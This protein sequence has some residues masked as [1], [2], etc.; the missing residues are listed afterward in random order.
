MK[1]V[2]MFVAFAIVAGA[3]PAFAQGNYYTLNGFVNCRSGQALLMPLIDS[4]YYPKRVL[5]KEY[6]IENNKFRIVGSWPYPF[7]ARIGVKVGG[8]LKYV[9][10]YFMVDSGRQNIVCNVY[11]LREIPD[12]GNRYMTEIKLYYQPAYSVVNTAFD[13]LSGWYDSLR[14]TYKNSI[15]DTFSVQ[16]IH[17]KS[18]IRDQSRRIVLDYAHEHPGSYC[19]DPLN[20]WTN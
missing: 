7:M 17:L 12:I 19:T 9:S 1:R 16:Y 20:G 2:L 4:S 6:T 13:A 10:D 18:K 5:F 14:S 15:P 11:S 8:E 3:G